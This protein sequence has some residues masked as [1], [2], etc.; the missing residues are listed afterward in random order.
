MPHRASGGAVFVDARSQALLT[1]VQRV[2]PSEASILLW[3]ESGSGKQTLARHVHALSRQA[4]GPFRGV[5]CGACPAGQLEHAMLGYEKG[6]FRGAFSA[7]AGW[8]ETA[9]G[10]TL[11]IDEVPR[12]PLHLQARLL[13]VLQSG[14]VTRLGGRAP[15]T[16]QVRL[17]AATNCDLAHAVEDGTFRE[18]LYYLLRVAPL[19]VP[20]LRERPGDILPLAEHFIER[21]RARLNYPPVTLCPETRQLLLQHAWPGNIRELENAVHHAMLLSQGS[22]LTPTCFAL[23]HRVAPA[24]AA[25]G[26]A[27][28][29]ALV[30]QLETALRQLY[31]ALPGEVAELVERSLFRTA[32]AHSRHNQVKTAQLLGL[33]RNVVRG[34]LIAHGEIDALK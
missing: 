15:V 18:D 27:P 14:E 9:S 32:F 3:G 6:A 13:H 16:V 10:G 29:A 2:A 25:T 17:I 20:A 1:H 34:R 33:S 31:E 5:N 19:H 4:A 12:L 22:V 7:A 28:R 30:A 21:Y 26:T 24:D 23:A 11:F 8:F